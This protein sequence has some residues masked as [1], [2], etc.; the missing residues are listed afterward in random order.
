MHNAH[1]TLTRRLNQGQN[2]PTS[3]GIASS[4]SS[5][6]PARD[7]FEISEAPNA[8]SQSYW[9]G[10]SILVSL[11]I[12]SIFFTGTNSLMYGVGFGLGKLF[13]SFGLA[14]PIFI[15]VKYV[16]RYGRRLP[17]KAS[18]NLLCV[19]IAAVWIM[20]A[21][22]SLALPGM[23][24]HITRKE[25]SI[26]SRPVQSSDFANKCVHLPTPSLQEFLKVARHDNPTVSD[27]S[28]T[29]YWTKTYSKR[30]ELDLRS[31]L[32]RGK[33]GGL[34]TSHLLNIKR[35][36]WQNTHEYSLSLEIIYSI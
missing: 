8:F 12:L 35:H 16:T 7:D 36:G 18:S 27:G 28:L 17:L 26:R 33:R 31:C 14:L 13:T 15:V 1:G 34:A 25:M 9:L 6:D 4:M 30:W 20:Q 32:D 22:L 21:I 10:V 23:I 5:N 11:A 3:P 19:L 29:E 24:D 2:A